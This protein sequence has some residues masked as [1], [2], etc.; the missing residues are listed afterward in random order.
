MHSILFFLNLIVFVLLLL[1]GYSYLFPPEKAIIFSLSGYAY[2]IIALVNLFFIIYW[3]FRFRWG[4]LISL[5][6]L[7]LTWN[8]QRAWFPIHFFDKTLPEQPVIKILTFNVMYFDYLK[9]PTEEGINPVISYIRDSGAD[10]VCLQEA[11]E[12]FVQHGLKQEKIKK[13]LKAYPY[14]VTGA[15]DGRYSVVCLSKYPVLRWERIPYPSLS[16]SS[17]WYDIRVGNQIIRLINNH[18]ESNKLNPAD[19][20]QYAQVLTNV[21]T[22]EFSRLA[23]KLGGKVGAATI[24]RAAQARAVADAIQASPYPVLVCGDFNDVPGS[25]VYKTIGRGLK[26]AW[27]EKGQGWGHTFHD[28]LFLFRID[29]VFHQPSLRVLS[30]QRDKVNLSDH[31]PLIVTVE[32]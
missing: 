19:K 10:I 28:Y 1:T 21:E 15:A 18:L 32:I 20:D 4:L 23:Q 31:Y 29:Y 12:T 2:P 16:N 22:R 8:V 9:N 13:A 24:T 14:K 3:L 7:F 6:A 17:Y 5:S 30:I 11:G 25:Y 27:V 26:D